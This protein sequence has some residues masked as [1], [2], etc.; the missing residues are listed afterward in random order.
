MNAKIRIFLC[1]LAAT[2][3]V[4]GCDDELQGLSSIGNKPNSV[5][6]KAPKTAP[7]AKAEAAAPI[8][9]LSQTTTTGADAPKPENK[10]GV[11]EP[12]PASEKDSQA[13]VIKEESVCQFKKDHL[14]PRL[15]FEG[16]NIILSG[17]DAFMPLISILLIEKALPET[18]W[19]KIPFLWLW[20]KLTFNDFDKIQTALQALPKNAGQKELTENFYY[21]DDEAYGSW[22]SSKY[23]D[24]HVRVQYTGLI[25]EDTEESYKYKGQLKAKI[26]FEKGAL[27][28]S[29]CPDNANQKSSP[30][31]SSTETPG[32][33]PPTPQTKP[34]QDSFMQ[35]YG[36][37]PF[38]GTAF[39]EGTLHR[40]EPASLTAA[41]EEPT[42]PSDLKKSGNGKSDGQISSYPNQAYKGSSL[43]P[44]DSEPSSPDTPLGIIRG[45]LVCQFI[46]DHLIEG[47]RINAL[48]VLII[49]GDTESPFFSILRQE[50]PEEGLLSF[51][52]FKLTETKV[53]TLAG[54]VGEK[55]TET[56]FYDPGEKYGE[57]C[58]PEYSDCVV[59]VSYTGWIQ[60]VKANDYLFQGTLLAQ[61]SFSGN[62]L[63]F[64]DCDNNM[65]N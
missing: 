5:V 9:D 34:Y 7:P 20:K 62:F 41:A 39:P 37:A 50:G 1:V 6:A 61:I 44:G 38:I 14:I 32:N 12:P 36:E 64:S 42:E 59:E 56:F 60:K 65:G 49:G 21:D 11:S 43:D 48:D 55:L 23:A 35:V 2:L 51:D 17:S 52:D 30:E 15:K 4:C 29:L 63:D 24:C 13:S 53:T 47:L 8:P 26:F 16:E 19:W 57:L 54:A 22:C 3:L 10:D 58:D 40:R 18:S 45:E 27:D 31:E 46:E 25:E 33:E 28:F